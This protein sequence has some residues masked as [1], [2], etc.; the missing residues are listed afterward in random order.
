MSVYQT[1]NLIVELQ[2]EPGDRAPALPPDVC[3][4]ATDP[5][6][7]VLLGLGGPVVSREPSSALLQVEDVLGAHLGAF[8]HPI[9][10]HKSLVRLLLHHGPRGL[11]DDQSI[12]ICQLVLKQRVDVAL[13]IVGVSREGDGDEVLELELLAG[14][15]AA[16]RHRGLLR[17][18]LRLRGLGRQPEGPQVGRLL[19]LVAG[20]GIPAG[21]RRRLPSRREVGGGGPRRRALVVHPEEGLLPRLL[22]LE[23]PLQLGVR[24]RPLLLLPHTKLALVFLLLLQ[25]VLQDCLLRVQKPAW[26][27]HRVHGRRQGQATV[28]KIALRVLAKPLLNGAEPHGLAFGVGHG[29]GIHA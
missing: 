12:P 9:R 3:Q 11:N 18:L 24:P 21:R 8:V 27:A 14:C 19:P 4:P 20:G 22:L 7:K 5:H 10:L 17:P 13:G 2:P 29:L 23:A 16:A 26:G 28:V 1:S 6:G 25:K 15:R